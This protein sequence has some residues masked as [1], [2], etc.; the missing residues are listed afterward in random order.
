MLEKYSEQYKKELFESV[1]PFW[2]DHSLDEEWG[3]TYSCLDRDGAVYDPKKYIWLVGRSVWM[4]S[5]LYHDCG[6]KEEYLKAAKLGVDFLDKNAVDEKGRYYFSTSRQGEPYFFQ[7]KPYSAVFAMMGYL[8]YAKVSGQEQYKQKAIELFWDITRWIEKPELLDRPIMAGAPAVSN[9]ANV[10]V[11]ASMAIELAEADDDPA[12]KTIMTDAVEGC[13]KHFDPSRRILVENVP[14]DGKDISGTPEGRF[15]IPGHSI[16]VAWFLLHILKY[17]PDSEAK[18]LAWDIVEGSLEYGWDKKYGGL[19]Y[20][21]DIENRPTLQLE[22]NMKLWWP[23]T[24]AIYALVL[25]YTQTKEQ[26]WLD[27]LEKVHDYTFSHF[28][29]SEYGGW[30]GYCDREG[31]LTHSCKGGNYKGFFHVPRALL[32]SIQAIEAFSGE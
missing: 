3:G 26:R 29:D 1:V 19:H 9:L 4:F 10:M 21:M 7:R 8:E 5:R 17:V 31:N 25:A 13:K 27:W 22:S 12:Y 18:N 2:L 16:E 15:F 14:L 28:V 30:Y 23:H 24:E 20:F 32:F 6:R 11:L